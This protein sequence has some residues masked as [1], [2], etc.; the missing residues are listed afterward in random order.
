LETRDAISPLLYNFALEYAIRSVQVNHVGLKLNGAHQL[1][2]YADV[3]IL[4]RSIYTIKKNREAIV[5]ASKE[6]G[7]EA[8]AAKTK[9]MVM[10]GDQKAGQIH[11]IKTDNSSF[12]RLEQIKYLA[13]SVRNLI[14]IQEEMKSRMK[15]GNTCCHSVQ[16]LLSFSL[17]SK[18]IKIKMDRTIILSVILY[19]HEAR[20]L[21]LREKL[22]LRVF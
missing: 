20:L 3:N 16:N 17:L 15:S 6:I 9:Y 10:S 21:I 19:G 1:L 11:N 8:N 5:F 12:G 14:S 7:L 18:N 4:G 2:V 22:R 13:T